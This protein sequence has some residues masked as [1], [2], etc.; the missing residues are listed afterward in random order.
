M[1]IHIFACLASAKVIE[2]V[3]LGKWQDKYFIVVFFG[4]KTTIFQ[5]RI[6]NI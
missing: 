5:L 6:R 1:L 4:V 3:P 2:N